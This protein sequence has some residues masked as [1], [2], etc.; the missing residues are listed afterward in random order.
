MEAAI[1]AELS[2][3]DWLTGLRA[4][5]S[6]IV[7]ALRARIR[8]GLRAALARRTQ[9]D[10]ADLDDFAQES[11]LRILDRLHTF[12]GDANFTTWAMAIAIRVSLT[13]LRK[14]RWAG[15][16]LQE[17]D[18]E[19]EAIGP[20]GGPSSERSELLHVLH[21]AI[22]EH[23][24][25]RQRQIL[26]GELAGVPQVVLAERLSATPGAIYK[27]SHDARKKLKTVLAAAGFDAR[28]VRNTLVST[29]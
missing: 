29:P 10:D 27:V 6:S 14:R 13:A 28:T 3:N 26:L 12:R 9:A 15:K 17:L 19:P 7:A 16:P 8:D 20:I 23:L 5:E 24:T 11:V 1:A 2:S 22:Q 21:D 25:P 18:F 4:G